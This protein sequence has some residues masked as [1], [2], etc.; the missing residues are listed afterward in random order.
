MKKKNQT[1]KRI[2]SFG[3]MLC[4]ALALGCLIFT[5]VLGNVPRGGVERTVAAAPETS[6]EPDAIESAEPVETPAPN[7]IEKS[8]SPAALAQTDPASGD[9]VNT[10]YFLGDG[11]LKLLNDETL[12]AGPEKDQQVWCPESGVMDLNLLS[13][14]TFLSPVTGNNAPFGDIAFVNRPATMVILPS[15]DNANMIT[16]PALKAAVK[17]VVTAIQAESPETKIILSSLTPVARS[18]QY[19]DIT[20]EVINRVNKWIAEAAVENNV[21]Y[22]DAAF[23]LA[24][25]DG[26]LPEN[27]Q[28]GDGMHL[29]ADGLKAWF[30]CVRT[31]VCP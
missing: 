20:F 4:L 3:I 18:Y 8:E 17:D 11:A 24:G 21:K 25:T 26:F 1:G 16:E 7:P 27:F 13:T 23:D 29:S 31:H 2:W 6:L 5:S 10:M 19:E 9:Y 15:T 14:V 12:L 22:L 28:N 30:N